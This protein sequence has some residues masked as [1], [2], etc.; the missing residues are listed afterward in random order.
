MTLVRQFLVAITTI[1]PRP[2][3]VNGPPS[4]KRVLCDVLPLRRQ[5]DHRALR[6]VKHY[7]SSIDHI[8][9]VDG[10]EF[11][12]PVPFSP[13]LPYERSVVIEDLDT[14]T[15]QRGEQITQLLAPRGEHHVTLDDSR[16]VGVTQPNQFGDLEFAIVTQLEVVPVEDFLGEQGGRSEEQDGDDQGDANGGPG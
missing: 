15:A 2:T 10:P 1:C 3:G 8:E 4:G 9:I 14:G 16:S 13:D 6:A 12:R 7:D 11:A 5:D